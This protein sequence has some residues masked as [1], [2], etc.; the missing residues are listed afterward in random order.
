MSKESYSD[1]DQEVTALLLPVTT[2]TTRNNKSLYDRLHLGPLSTAALLVIVACYTTGLTDTGSEI[3]LAAPPKGPPRD[4]FPTQSGFE[5]PTPTGREPLA[6]ATAYPSY[7]DISPILPPSHLNSS[8]SP[9]PAER[10]AIGGLTGSE[11]VQHP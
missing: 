10:R 11:T 6:A 5:G 1:G 8:V 7:R 2:A 4:K 3:S 9:V